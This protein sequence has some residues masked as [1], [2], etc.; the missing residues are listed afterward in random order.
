MQILGFSWL[1]LDERGEGG[2]LGLDMD[3]GMVSNDFV[4]DR[5]WVGVRRNLLEMKSQLNHLA[6]H[7]LILIAQL[8]E[9]FILRALSL[10]ASLLRLHSLRCLDDSDALEQ[11][12]NMVSEVKER[13]W[14]GVALVLEEFGVNLDWSL[15]G[16]KYGL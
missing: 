11:V 14:T 12:G 2:L 10:L 13:F 1:N 5:E 9:C 16:G 15:I 8:G 7:S 4:G 3:I 6:L